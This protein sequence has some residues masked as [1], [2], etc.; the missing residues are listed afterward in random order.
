MADSKKSLMKGIALGMRSGSVTVPYPLLVHYRD[1]HLSDTEAMLLIQ[2]LAFQQAEQNDFPSMEQLERRLDIAPGG[3]AAVLRR[4]LKEGWI[5]IDETVDEITGVQAER[6]NLS[7]MYERLGQFLAER[8]SSLERDLL[9]EELGAEPPEGQERNLFV[10]FEKEFARPLSP[11]ECETISG[12][13]DQD[14][15]PEELILLALKEAVFAGKVHFRYIDRILLEW[16]RNRV[17][18]AEDARAYTQRFRGGMR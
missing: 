18:T 14:Q 8:Q 15:Y 1:L 11:M 5:S 3:L 13:V 10:I 6:Y 2:L 9:R 12:W 7:G 17:R 16:S 4:L